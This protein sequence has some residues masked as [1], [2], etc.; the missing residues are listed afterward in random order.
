M[1]ESYECYVARMLSFAQWEY[2][3]EHFQGARPITN[4]SNESRTRQALVRHKL[5]GVDAQS[6]H[7]I[8]TEKGH[9]V[10]C[11]ARGM[12]ADLIAEY[13]RARPMEKFGYGKIA[14][15]ARDPFDGECALR[16]QD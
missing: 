3:A 8:L 7:T 12:M 16:E 14:S 10:M 15:P 1:T 11:A 9:T 4:A 5:I 13:D 6:K 2:L